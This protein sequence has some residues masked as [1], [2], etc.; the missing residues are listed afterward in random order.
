MSQTDVL[1]VG[2]GISGLS[3][4]WWLSQQGVSVEIW[5]ADERIGGKIKST[6]QDGYLTERAASMVMNFRPEVTELLYETGLDAVKTSRLPES[7]VRRY[8]L[9]NKQL[10]ALPMRMG[11]MITSPLWSLRGKLRLLAE[12]FIPPCYRQD[13]TVSQ[14]VT[15]RFGKEMLEK[16]MEPFVAG[17]LA[18]DSDLASAA[19]CLPRLTALERKYGSITAGVLINRL[20]RRR[21]ACGTETFSFYGGIETLVETL[22]RTPGVQ[23]ATRFQVTGLERKT[24]DWQITANTPD[25]ERV[26]RASQ[27]VVTTPA[28]KTAE[29]VAPF[30]KKLAHLLRDI[31][32]APVNV[33]HMG[34]DR[35][36]I[37]HALDGT[38]FLVPRNALNKENQGL[39]GNLWMSSLFPNRAP[40]GKVLLSSYI[41]GARMPEVQDWD[42]EHC[43]HKTLSCLSHL[44]GIK[45]EPEMVKID[46][47]VQALPLYHGAH[48]AR[49]Q[50]IASHLQQIPGLH[51]E[52]NYRGGV[53]VRDRIARSR[54]MAT[55]IM[56][57]LPKPG[58]ADALFAPVLGPN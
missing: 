21:T 47:H 25:G 3:L 1:I 58:R 7:E 33:V 4:A 24:R 34:F 53:S 56:A 12:P 41:G 11:S 18:A 52:A 20:L 27:V 43:L 42:T 32:Y 13:E 26:L 39:T 5:E 19:A 31:H 48:Q 36:A 28:A 51:L 50:S 17:T 16:A 8:L 38:G 57:S 10:T 37:D 14:F 29:L 9:H 44:L 22:A 23:I 30:N 2:A 6:R 54:V 55:K 45:G 46:R 40:N 15:R 35:T 49:L